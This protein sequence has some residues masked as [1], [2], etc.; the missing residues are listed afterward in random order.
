[1]NESG[2]VGGT[3]A[4]RATSDQSAE[5]KAPSQSVDSDR[6]D[7][8]NDLDCWRLPPFR[9]NH[10]AMHRTLLD[11]WEQVKDLPLHFY[12][13][14]AKPYDSNYK[15]FAKTYQKNCLD[16]VYRMLKPEFYF[17]VKETNATKT[18]VHM[19][20]G[21]E[22][23]KYEELTYRKTARYKYHVD[24]VNMAPKS[25]ERLF[26]YLIK[27]SRHRKLNLYSDYK[28]NKFDN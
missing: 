1:M 2:A 24:D 7:P 12:Y 8:T 14:V 25:I 11:W 16:Y 22:K 3:G 6:D 10:A 26:E 20:V 23:D 9:C 13:I 27:E 15:K 5:A 17:M 19:I 28:C 18:H 4:N 21:E